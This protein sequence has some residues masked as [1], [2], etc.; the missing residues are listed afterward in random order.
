M[1]R[2]RKLWITLLA[3]PLMLLAADTLYWYLSELNLEN[4]FAAWLA[5]RRAAGW[6]ANVEAPARGGW[7]VAA[8]LTVRDVSLSGGTPFFSG[9]VAWSTQR[10]TLRVA[11]L[12]PN[13]IEVVAD[14]AQRL[15]LADSP[16]IAAIADRFRL[17]MPLQAGLPS[18]VDVAAENLRAGVPG[19]GEASAGTLHLHM[20]L[21]ADAPSGES[22]ATFSLTAKAV[23][24]PAPL[25]RTLGSNIGAL[26]VEG[27]LNGPVS[28]S[29]TLAERVAAW[30][31]S[32]GSLEIRRLALAWGPLDLT[33]SATL[34]L[35][36]D[37]QPMGAGSAR[38][39][40]YS[41]TLDA[42]AAHGAITRSAATA[43]KAVLSLLAH[44]PEDGSPPD[45]EVPLTLQYRTLSMRQVP[46]I[47][48]PE[49]DWP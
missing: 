17:T 8:M 10:L 25:D 31:D 18:F 21:R 6:T 16:Q 32:G 33:A 19:G 39:I 36:E 26:G 48:L 44:N 3:V 30:R 13:R 27:A 14:G 15:R 23:R 34:A 40:G 11:L 46:L 12:R 43:A 2:R 22:A 9:A 5:E 37:L 42:L 28:S 1:R 29:G 45:V 47:R 49:L 20:H 35:D 24:P 41:E 7:P 38:A 4:G